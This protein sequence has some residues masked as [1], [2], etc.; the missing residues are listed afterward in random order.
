MGVSGSGKTTVGRLFAQKTGAVFY[1]GDGFHPA[2]NIEK[3]SRGVPLTDGD[4]SKWLREL[5]NIILRSLETGRFTVITC[6]ALKSAYRDLLQGEDPRVKFIH[7]TGPRAVIEARLKARR[8]HF[9]P[10]TLL[11]S[12]LATLEPPMNALTFNCER[13]PEEIVAALIQ[14]LSID[15][16]N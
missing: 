15:E 4:R 7:L 5:R 6:S 13:P 12:Q 16:P 10:A 3:M 9:M 8:G 14:T 2:E 1:E 11:E